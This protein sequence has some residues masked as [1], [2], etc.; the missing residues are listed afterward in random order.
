MRVSIIVPAL[1]EAAVLQPL[2]QMLSSR[3]TEVIVVDGGSSDGS[4]DI[5]RQFA[6]RCLQSS[7]GRACQMNAGAAC[8][9]GEWLWFVHADTRLLNPLD[10]Y[11][12]FI[13]TDRLLGIF[14]AGIKQ[15]RFFLSSD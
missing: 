1:N 8:A 6:D 13:E 10:E 15:P 14:W 2:L 4:L 12:A 3:V 11:L 5:A 7:P 9:G